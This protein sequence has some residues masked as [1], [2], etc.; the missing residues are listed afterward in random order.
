[1]YVT[2]ALLKSVRSPSAYG[3]CDDSQ[4]FPAITKAV[5]RA[6]DS[7][8]FDPSVGQIDLCICDGCV[9]LPADVGTILSVNQG[10]SPTVIRSQWYEF[11][12]NGAGSQ[13]CAPCHYVTVAGFFS[14]I[15]EVNGPSK[16]IA[17]LDSAA[18]S[19]KEVRVFGW[20]SSGKRIYTDGQDGFL[21]PTVY[22]FPTPNPIAPDIARI[23]RVRKA[24]TTGFV[25]LISYRA[26]DDTRRALLGN[27]AP[28]ETAPIY[29]RIRVS[30]RTFLR[31]K[32]RR[33]DIEVRGVGDWININNEEA[34]MFLL[35]AVKLGEQD[36]Y[37][38]SA[39]AE[40]EGL[41][42]LSNEQ[43]SASS[44]AELNQPTIIY[45]ERPRGG[46]ATLFY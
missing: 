13:D 10:R 35:K 21:V 25:K 15:S 43:N 4:V 46:A 12:L 38:A 17:E 27:Y 26:N 3:K 37:D 42:L 8:L 6:N 9:T 19:Q 24:E 39:K 32:Y 31:V 14:T 33:K 36:A 34:L 45:H 1:M 30:S 41:R 44:P 5:K 11:S 22:G 2:E 16:I 29:Q 7:G 20:D 28:W 18:D 23:D 40:K